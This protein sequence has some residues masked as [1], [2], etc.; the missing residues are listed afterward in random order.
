MNTKEIYFLLMPLSLKR[1]KLNKSFNY[2]EI[3]TKF[4][5]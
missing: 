5:R 1:K 2:F 4:L 3:T